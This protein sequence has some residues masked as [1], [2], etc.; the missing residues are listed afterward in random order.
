M[1]KYD[2]LVIGGGATGVFTALDLTLRGLNVAL[3]ERGMLASGTSGRFHGLLHS[4]ARYAT[5]D[6][7]SAKECIQENQIISSIAPHAVVDTGGLFVA[8]KK[9]DLDFE[10]EFIKGLKENGIPYKNIS[11]EEVLKME[12]NINPEV[13]DAVWVPDKVVHAID[14]IFSAAL[15]AAINGATFYTF[16]EVVDFIKA[17]NRVEGV[18]VHNKVKDRIEEIRADL[19]VNAAG[20]W[21][22]KLL[23][24]AGIKM[25]MLPT[26]GAMVVL[27]ERLNVHVLN[28]MRPPS[29]G[30]I[31]VP[32]SDN[33]SI[34][35]T[36]A[37]IIEDVD[38]AS[39]S[40]DD[41]DLLL[42]EG[43]VMVPKV[44]EVGV[45]RTY[46]SIRP[47]LKESAGSS[48]VTGRT[49]T[50]TFKLFDHEGDGLKGLITVMGG[51]L[52]TARLMGEKVGDYVA[53]KLNVR[54]E[55][56]TRSTK[57][58]DRI[59]KENAE[60]LSQVTGLSYSF[61]K[62]LLDFKGSIDEER[63]RPFITMLL[64]YGLGQV[65]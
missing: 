61:I 46:Y 36:T 50:R 42:N 17:G 15:T 23:S 62:G 35:G 64:A 57:L 13:K 16:R 41:I 7:E 21:S 33:I 65:M 11:R 60:Y 10:E 63:I 56:K 51:K 12:P 48:Q 47:L 24:K 37:S 34:V 27:G 39:V 6:P 8:I 58:V 18:K 29:D 31:I 45:L 40:Q 9:P 26:L 38:N 53:D 52:T 14:L 49:A 3:V 1:V 20:P 4:G 5:N 43:S 25:E 44:K 59:D 54:K 19:I 32:Y 30:D 2:V 22:T 28:R 55:S